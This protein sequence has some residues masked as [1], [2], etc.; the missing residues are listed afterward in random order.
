MPNK[1]F[2]HISDKECGLKPFMLID[3]FHSIVKVKLL[4]LLVN[5]FISPSLPV[6]PPSFHEAMSPSLYSSIQHQIKCKIKI[7]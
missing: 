7:G 3:C 5:P 1:Y 4:H 2:V 6:L